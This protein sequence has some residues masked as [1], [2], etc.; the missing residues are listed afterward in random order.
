MEAGLMNRRSFLTVTALAGGG[1][2]VATYF[3][4]LTGLLAQAPAGPRPTFVANAFVRITPE[5]S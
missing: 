4:P 1:M 3:D 5:T 2:L